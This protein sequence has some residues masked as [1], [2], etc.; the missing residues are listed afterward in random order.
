M[1]DDAIRSFEDMKTDVSDA[2]KSSIDEDVSFTVETDASDHAIGATLNQEGRPVAFFSRKLG[3]H[4]KRYSIV[5]KEATAIVESLKRWRHYLIGKKFTLLTDQK[6]VSFMLDPKSHGKIKNEKICRWRIELSCFS[7]VIQ[8]RTG[9]T[10]SA[11]D[12]LSR[13]YNCSM[14]QTYTKLASLHSDLCH[15]GVSRMIHFVRSRNMPYSTEDVK[16]VIKTCQVCSRVKPSFASPLT[17]TLI[18]ATRPFERLS[19]DFKGPV[20][21]STKNKYLFTIID[22]YSR[23]PF[24][25]PCQDMTASTVIRCFSQLF[26]IFGMPSYIHSDR[27]QTFLS[28]ELREFLNGKGIATSHSTPY[29]PAGNGQIERLNGTLWRTLELAAASKNLNIDH[30]EY[31]LPDALHSIRSLL[32]TATNE[33][34]HERMFKY[35]RKSTNG[36]AIPTWLLNSKRVL[37]RR[38]VRE[39]KYDPLV[40]E[41]ELVESNPNYA[42]IRNSDGKES[43]VSLK[44][45]A[46][47]PNENTMPSSP[48]IRL[49]SDPIP[50]S[51]SGNPEQPI[52]ESPPSSSPRRST[53]TRRPPDRLQYSSWT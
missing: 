46:P 41:V 47:L 28:G 35:T 45:L 9:K 32:C 16:N 18:R 33:T 27:A 29:N 5:E 12:L 49:D 52:E 26:S 6:S 44:H 25:F 20:P 14:S 8:Y 4:E 17:P 2:A 40:D 24:A 15:P 39:S 53:R 11:A 48:D 30:W 3:T 21:S 37:L 43:T 42:R 10:N 34:P 31:L 36:S 13:S 1:S 50:Q 38:Y 23:F 7:F 22:E 19:V 51:T